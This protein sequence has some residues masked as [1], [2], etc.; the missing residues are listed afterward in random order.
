MSTTPHQ[1]EHDDDL[2]LAAEAGEYGAER[3]TF[4]TLRIVL[5]VVLLL[6]R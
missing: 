1:P 4:T 6:V 3:G 2:L 5:A